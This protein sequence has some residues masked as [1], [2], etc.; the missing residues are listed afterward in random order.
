[1][2]Y[3]RKKSSCGSSEHWW[4][5][6]L[7]WSINLSSF[8]FVFRLMSVSSYDMPIFSLLCWV[9][10]IHQDYLLSVWICLFHLVSSRRRLST[11]ITAVICEGNVP[12]IDNE[13]DAQNFFLFTHMT[14]HVCIQWI[15]FISNSSFISDLRERLCMSRYIFW[16]KAIKKR[17]RRQMVM[18]IDQVQITHTH[19]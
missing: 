10:K 5:F 12:R 8:V 2:N 9:S 18:R 7:T 11:A 15:W 4:Y 3:G 16:L 17:W 13:E 1:M 19:R 6:I 14:Q